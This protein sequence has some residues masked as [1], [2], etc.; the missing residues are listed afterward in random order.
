MDGLETTANCPAC[1]NSKDNR[2]FSGSERMFGMGGE[3]TYGECAK[4]LAVF[5]LEVPENLE[6]YYSGEYYSFRELVRS[7]LVGGILKKLRYKLYRRGISLQDPVYFPWL[8]GLQA[9]PTDRIAD[10]GCG[11]GQLL[12]ELSY[13]GFQT[14]HGYDPFLS[15]SKEY[16]GLSLRKTDY[17]DIE[18]RYDILMLH[19][20]FEHIADPVRVFEK[21]GEIMNPGGRILIRVPVTDGQVWKDEKEFWFQLDAPRHLFIPNTETIRLLAAKVG[22]EVYQIQFDSTGSQ[23]IYT[24]L[25]K[26]GRTLHDTDI[27]QEFSQKEIEDFDQKAAQYNAQNIGDQACFYL[28]KIKK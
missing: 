3:F 10:I 7:S 26:R 13:C 11:N 6:D 5:I 14:L 4:C 21:F 18:E 27:T 17:F 22:L 24:E 2:F 8:R 20:S 12:G 15:V 25:Y 19:H 28:R 16:P 23:F 9:K 1:G